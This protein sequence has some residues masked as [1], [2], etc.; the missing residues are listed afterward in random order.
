MCAQS[1]SRV[2]LYA[3]P[4][5][6]ARQA[7][8]VHGISQARI[9]EWV[10]IS[11][12]RGSSQS[13]DQTLVSSLLHWQTDFLQLSHLESPQMSPRENK[14]PAFTAP[15]KTGPLQHS[16]MAALTSYT[17]VRP[18][19]PCFLSFSCFN[20]HNHHKFYLFISWSG[21]S[22]L[23]KRFYYCFAFVVSCFPALKKFFI[24]FQSR[25]VCQ[26]FLKHSLSHF[27]NLNV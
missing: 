13:R 7:L 16:T 25:S 10:A 14:W 18:W 22:F 4:W 3:I 24:E 5:T 20:S 27:F 8:S 21:F 1:F 2:W 19:N 9:L 6:V 15:Q 23:T 12:P 26:V 11:S 17:L